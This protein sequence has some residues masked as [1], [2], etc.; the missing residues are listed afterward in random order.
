MSEFLAPILH[1]IRRHE[2]FCSAND[3]IENVRHNVEAILNTRMSIP[4]DYILRPTDESSL[5][6]LND[7]LLNFGVADFQ[8]LNMGDPEMEKRFCESVKRAIQRFEPRLAGVTVEM[9]A[10]N[11]KRL[12]NIQVR[13]KLVVQPFENIDFASGLDLATKK[14]VVG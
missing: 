10:S 6:L 8:S 13:G 1:R 7:S 14:F 4:G 3:V 9:V 12:M 2:R 11:S 5:E